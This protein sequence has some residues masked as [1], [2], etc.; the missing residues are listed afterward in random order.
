MADFDNPSSLDEQLRSVALPPGL[1]DRLRA[2]TALGDAA[3][4]DSALDRALSDVPLP[5]ELLAR[6]REIAT[7][8][9][10]EIDH[11]LRD[12]PVPEGLLEELR[13]IGSL[14]EPDLDA[15]L[16]DVPLPL[17]MRPRL[18]RNVRW[19]TQ[20]TQWIG[21]AVAASLL[22]TVSIVGWLISTQHGNQ[23][24]GAD[25]KAD[26]HT[27][28]S[29]IDLRNGANRPNSVPAPGGIAAKAPSEN[30]SEHHVANV[31]ANNGSQH[32]SVPSGNGSGLADGGSPQAP[33]PL[34]KPANVESVFG[35]QIDSPPDLNALVPDLVNRGFSGPRVKQYDLAFELLHGVHPFVNPAASPLLRECRVPT[36]MSTASYDL[37]GRTL[38]AGAWPVASQIRVEDFLAAQDFQ[39]PAPSGADLGIRTAGGPSPVSGLGL[40]LLQVGVQA[41]GVIRNPDSATHLTIVVDGSSDMRADE[42]WE[43]V[44]RT[45]DRLSQQLTA[46]DRVSLV[47]AGLR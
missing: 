5:V 45:L 41:A 29:Q 12:V 47:V 43:L 7:L 28:A 27:L 21:L 1:L 19:Q 46:D 9:D 3:W 17:G 20:R 35:G 2:A 32:N 16:R 33:N 14:A 40:S 38:Q 10:A 23:Q 34:A 26:N 15:A 24:A 13:L 42:R 25:P 8:G 4:D 39:F 37:V 44:G 11:R 31:P 30:G 18:G 22:I 6:L 36:E